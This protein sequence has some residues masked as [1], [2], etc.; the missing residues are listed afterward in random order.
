MRPCS[1]RE[2]HSLQRL[3]RASVETMDERGQ[4]H[5]ERIGALETETARQLSRQQ[6]LRSARFPA[7]VRAKPVRGTSSSLRIATLYLP[8]IE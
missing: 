6:T 5:P 1:S 8:T 4:A 2:R 3:G 7:S